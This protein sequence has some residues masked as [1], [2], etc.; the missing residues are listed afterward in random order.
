MKKGFK[1]IFPA[2]VR[3]PIIFTMAKNI[4]LCPIS[5]GRE[6]PDTVG[7]MVLELEGEQEDLEER[8]EKR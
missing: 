3:E 6:L 7:E 5:E 1:L 2:S 8:P 4:T